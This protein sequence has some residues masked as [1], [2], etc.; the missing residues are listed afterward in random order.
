MQADWRWL[1]PKDLDLDIALDPSLRRSLVS[2][3]DGE[4]ADDYAD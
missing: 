1:S 4:Q 3:C 2:E